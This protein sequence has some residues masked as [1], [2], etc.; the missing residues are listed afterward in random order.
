MINSGKAIYIN[1]HTTIPINIMGKKI[2]VQS[3]FMIP[4]DAFK[5]NIKNF[6]TNQIIQI[7]NNNVNI[8]LLLLP[9]SYT[10]LSVVI[11]F[12]LSETKADVFLIP[13]FWLNSGFLSIFSI[14]RIIFI[15][16]SVF[17]MPPRFFL[18]SIS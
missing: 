7:V 1:P 2:T 10:W 14:N 12:D 9:S 11:F 4:Q 13:I 3:N 8:L 16:C 15:L 18:A 6:P 17:I 5:P